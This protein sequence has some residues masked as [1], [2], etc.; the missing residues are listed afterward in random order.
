MARRKRSTE[1]GQR[2]AHGDGSLEAWTSA[3]RRER[4][5]KALQRGE[6]GLRELA[7]NLLRDGCYLL[8]AAFNLT[9]DPECPYRF[10]DEARLEVQGSIVKL[11]RQMQTPI[12]VARAG[13]AAQD[14][15]FQRFIAKARA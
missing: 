15:D 4:Y 11:L 5:L 3:I 2:Q 9:E 14:P 13:I 8:E 1:S 6:P 10:S 7:Q 12:T